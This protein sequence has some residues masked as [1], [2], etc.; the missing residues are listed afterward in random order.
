MAE[1]GCPDCGAPTLP[2]DVAC[3]ACGYDYIMGRRPESAAVQQARR[4]GRIAGLLAFFV[5]LPL[6]GFVL[7][8]TDDGPSEYVDQHPCLRALRR[9]Q[10][11]VAEIYGADVE[12]PL[13]GDTP[14]GPSDCWSGGASWAP[15]CRAARR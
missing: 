13:C 15:T 4:Y 11:I 8:G 9:L 14:P 3:E 1:R 5:G 6:L 12:L 7:F 2:G 10:P